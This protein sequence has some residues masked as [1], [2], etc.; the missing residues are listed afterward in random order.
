[1]L[2]KI[3]ALGLFLNIL[4]ISQISA[5]IILLKIFLQKKKEVYLKPKGCWQILVVYHLPKQSRNFGWNVNESLFFSFRT[6]IFLGKRDFLKGSPKFPNGIYK[7]K[8]C[9]P[10]AS[11]HH[12]QAFRQFT[13]LLSSVPGLLSQFTP[14]PIWDSRLRSLLTICPNWV[15]RSLRLNGKQL[16]LSCL[17]LETLNADFIFGRKLTFLGKAESKALIPHGWF[18]NIKDIL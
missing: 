14:N 6:E 15:K 16:P 12:F 5:S 7:W 2:F 4:K 17:T 3:S 10:F 13:W 8:E 1:M 9:L 18:Q 11:L